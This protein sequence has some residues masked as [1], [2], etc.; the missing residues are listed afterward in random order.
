[1]FA[2]IIVVD[3]DIIP[4]VLAVLGLLA[5]LFTFIAVRHTMAKRRQEKERLQDK[6]RQ[7]HKTNPD[8]TEYRE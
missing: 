7:F 6:V 5:V 3:A 8:G 2:A 4:Y 1:M